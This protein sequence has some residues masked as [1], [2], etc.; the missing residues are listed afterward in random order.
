MAPKIAALGARARTSLRITIVLLLCSFAAATARAGSVLH[1]DVTHKDDRYTVS[2]D[3]RIAAEHARVR[4]YLTDYARY[5]ERFDS[6]TESRILKQE[7]NKT[8][9]LLRLH[10]C[11]LFFCKTV[12]LV[13]RIETLPDGEIVARVDPSR[14]DFQFAEEHWRVLPD[15]KN[16][17]LQY[18]AEL[19]PA[20][21]VPPVIGPWVMKWRIRKVL[22]SGAAKLEALAARE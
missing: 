8:E 19:V 20:F 11:V 3:M 2:F 6:I 4:R 13:K 18:R 12:T 17:R 5:G 22:H 1:T 15:G 7:K 10:S 14:S 21:Y 16:T 9:L